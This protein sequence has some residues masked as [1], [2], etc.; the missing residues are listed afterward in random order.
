MNC[1]GKGLKSLW[2]TVTSLLSGTFKAINYIGVCLEQN[3]FLVN[4][5][6]S[7]SNDSEAS[8]ISVSCVN[9]N[10]D[11]MRLQPLSCCVFCRWAWSSTEEDVHQMGELSLRPSDLSHRW[12]V[13]RPA[14]WP[15]AYP[16][17]GSALRR[18]AGQYYTKTTL[19]CP[20]PDPGPQHHPHPAPQVTRK[21]RSCTSFLLSFSVIYFSS[22]F[23]LFFFFLHSCSL[24]LFM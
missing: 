19:L 22:S 7:D 11:V 23:Y 13:Y 21:E 3:W 16:P 12:L 20:N 15:H 14:W 6:F 2:F 10:L 1:S 18:T 8:G 9:C 17:A 24:F 5:Y 4:I